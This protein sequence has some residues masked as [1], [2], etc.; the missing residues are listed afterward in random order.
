M[1]DINN[2]KIYSTTLYICTSDGK[3][4]EGTGREVWVLY[5]Q[6][7]ITEEEIA[8]LFKNEM[9]EYDTR[10]TEISP[11]RLRMLQDKENDDVK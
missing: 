1:T 8:E 2:L 3:P 10:L 4:V 7:R 11:A 9:W 6:T 5:N